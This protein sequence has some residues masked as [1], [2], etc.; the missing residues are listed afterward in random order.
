MYNVGIFS[1]QLYGEFADPFKLAECKL[2]IIHCAGY[3]DP[4]LVQTLWQDIIEKGKCS[5]TGILAYII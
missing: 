1:Q 2:A 3:S 5:L 4:I